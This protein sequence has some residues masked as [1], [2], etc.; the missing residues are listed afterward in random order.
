MRK[1]ILIPLIL[2]SISACSDEQQQTD[3]G[4]PQIQAIDKAK[5]VEQVLSDSVKR[6]EQLMN[7]QIQ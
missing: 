7:E 5:Q 2:L 1:H 3:A 4:Q 6:R